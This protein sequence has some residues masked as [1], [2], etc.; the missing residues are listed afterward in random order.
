MN[1]LENI[2]YVGGIIAGIIAT[3]FAVKK[4]LKEKGIS[5][6]KNAFQGSQDIDNLLMAFANKNS[7]VDS[8][9]L[10][11]CNNG[12]G[13]PH[14]TSKIKTSIISEGYTD[15]LYAYKE[16]WQEQDVEPYYKSLLS[17]CLIEGNIYIQNS[18]HLKEGAFKDAV[19]ALNIKAFKLIF[20]QADKRKWY[21]LALS[22]VKENDF[23]NPKLK[24]D[25]R[26]L[27]E[28]LIAIIDG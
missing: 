26:Y 7:E 13:V 23:E 3:L 10:M 20:I 12:G 4:S 15:N 22:S 2:E 18:N 19:I 5:I 25:S 9:T 8:A 11:V 1:L 28:Q 27:I 21:Y 24:D 16:H 6:W 17:E 14:P